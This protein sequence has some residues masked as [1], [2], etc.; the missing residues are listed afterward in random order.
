[1]IDFGQPSYKLNNSA[2]EEN[3]IELARLCPIVTNKIH[4]NVIISL[5]FPLLS[6]VIVDT[7]CFKAPL[8]ISLST[9]ILL[10]WQ[11]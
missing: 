8:N 1:M 5:F 4:S 11:F 7:A 10:F 3:L 2:F 9:I 6:D